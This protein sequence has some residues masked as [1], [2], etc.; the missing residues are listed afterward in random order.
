MIIV[1]FG[2]TCN[3]VNNNNK[4][5]RKRNEC[6]SV[7]YQKLAFEDPQYNDDPVLVDLQDSS[8]II[9]HI[10]HLLRMEPDSSLLESKFLSTSLFD[11]TFS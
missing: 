10:S 9:R 11:I 3:V 4:R 6:P 2:Y 8:D 5:P 7:K 1:F